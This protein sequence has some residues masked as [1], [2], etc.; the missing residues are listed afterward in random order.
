MLCLLC[1][2]LLAAAASE[3]QSDGSP[4]EAQ[5]MLNFRSTLMQVLEAV[6]QVGVPTLSVPV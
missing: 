4:R 3:G 2:Y 6:S 1:R 5:H